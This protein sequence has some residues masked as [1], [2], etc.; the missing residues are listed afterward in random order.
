MMKKQIFTLIELLV[1]IAII[2]ILASML[3]PALTK[4]RLKA[5]SVAC[6]SNLKQFGIA[7]LMYLADA[8]DLFQARDYGSDRIWTWPVPFMSYLGC[9]ETVLD[10]SGYVLPRGKSMAFNCPSQ[11]KLL[12]TSIYVSYGYNANALGVRSYNNSLPINVYCPHGYN[13]SRTFPLNMCR[14]T[15]PSSQLVFADTWYNRD[16]QI[17]RQ[18]GSFDVNVDTLCYR[19]AQKCNAVYADGH[20]ESNS[21]EEL[22]QSDFCF[23]PFNY[24]MTNQPWKYR[25]GGVNFYTLV[26]FAPY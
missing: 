23:Y 4:A 21:V 17:N 25:S 13:N 6:T 24:R 9:P 11:I 16:T 7:Q 20:V 10:A 5:K 22:F 3:L 2:A 14:I 15:R 1:V 26:G 8:N 18:Y 19:H 12:D